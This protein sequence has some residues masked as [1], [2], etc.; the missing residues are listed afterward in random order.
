MFKS[1]LP[2]GVGFAHAQPDLLTFT[3]AE[4]SPGTTAAAATARTLAIAMSP[5]RLDRRIR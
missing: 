2:C 3:F 4:L 5:R 1:V